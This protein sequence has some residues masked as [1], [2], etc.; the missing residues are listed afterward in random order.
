MDPTTNASGDPSFMPAAGPDSALDVLSLD[1]NTTP[2]LSS[3]RVTT[4]PY[5]PYVPDKMGDA[6]MLGSVHGS[7]DQFS[8]NS[9][10]S[11]R[12][13]AHL[14][15]TTVYNPYDTK[16]ALN[17][18]ER[19]GSDRSAPPRASSFAAA[20]SALSR[21]LTT[22][23]LASRS[24][25]TSFVPSI[26]APT[27][28][29]ANYAS[30]GINNADD[31]APSAQRPTNPM[32][33]ERMFR[34]LMDRRDFRSLPQ[35]ARQEMMNYGVD[36]KWMLIYQD[37]LS[38]RN[39][40]AK[41]A[42]A[43]PEL[44]TRKL[45]SKQITCEELE[46]LWVS[47]RT[48]PID[49]VREFIFDFQG[50]VALSLY[51]IKVHDQIGDLNIEHILDDIFTKELN[52]LKCL[53]CMMN[54][55]LG[56]ERAKADDALY[57]NAISGALL[58]PRL[59]TRRIATE[60]LTFLIV[61]Y[62]TSGSN[63]HKSKYH[64]VLKALDSLSTR[65]YYEFV[66]SAGAPTSMN[67][68]TLKR[69]F[70][71]SSLS[72]RFQLWLGIVAR[73]LG[74][75]GKYH[76]SLVGASEE[77]KYASSTNNASQV[78]N[79]LFEY[80]LSTMLLVNT[81]VEYGIDFRAR[82][83]LRSQLKGA[84]IELLMQNFE[85]MGF[86][87]LS[88]QC[89]KYADMA[90]ADEVELKA[91]ELIDA[92]IDFN[93][94]V[95][96]VNSLWSLVQNSEA[97]GVFISTIQ[98]LFL[99]QMDK[100][101]DPE[102]RMRSLR[103]LDGLVQNV[104]SAHTND[105]SAIGIAMNRLFQG[106]TTDD[107]Y[108]KALAEVKTQRK[109]A[110][111]ATAERDEMS[112]Q[113]SLGS[114]GLITSLTN[115]VREQ[116][117]VL[118]RTRKLNEEM[119]DELEEFKRKYLMEKQEQEMEMRELLIM[120]NSADIKSRRQDGKTTYSV[121]TSNTELVSK[122]QNQ[123]NRKKRE[124]RLDNKQLRSLIEP[125]SRLR[126]LREQMNDIENLARELEMTDF[127][128]YTQ[129]EATEIHVE[130][131]HNQI[132]DLAE[133][134]E[135]SEDELPP[136][137]A[138]P[139]P[140]PPV[141]MGPRR[142]MRN[143]DLEK[144]SKLRQQLSSLQ[145][146]SN[147]IMKF[148]NSKMFSKQK[149]LAMD[150][151][152]EL[153]NNFKDF[154]IDFD[155]SEQD[156][157][158]IAQ[159][160]DVN[161]KSRLQEEL[162]EIEKLKADLHSQLNALNKTNEPKTPKSKRAS[163]NPTTPNVDLFNKIESKY[164][165]GK[166][167]MESKPFSETKEVDFRNMKTV[168]GMDPKF[169]SE[170]T[171]K[172]KKTEAIDSTPE[173]DNE[174]ENLPIDD[175]PKTTPLVDKKEPVKA[176]PPPPPPPPL[177]P[178]LGG[179]E[180][181]PPPPPPPP[182]PPLLGGLGSA[183]PPPPLPPLL[184]GGGPPPP[185]PPP[186]M[187]GGLMP[188]PPPP[189][190][191]N[192]LGSVTPVHMPSPVPNLFD[193]YPRPKKKLKQLHWEKMDSMESN[194]MSFWKN[195]QPQTIVTQL[196]ERGV[197]DEI[198]VIFAAKEIRNLATKKKE[199]V[200]KI[201]FLPR[202][203]AQQFGINLHFFNLFSDKEVV[204]KILRCDKDVLENPTVL[205]FL[206]KDE[207]VE[208]PNSLALSLQPYST[209]YTSE[210]LAKPEKDPSE[211]Q[212]SDR[213]YLELI[214][215]LQHYWKSRIRALRTIANYE[216]DYDDL[217]FK[218]R[219]IDQSVLKIK[220]SENLRRVFEI[221]L[222]VGN[223]MN[224]SSKQAKGFKL[225]SLQR[226]GFVKDDKNSMSFLHYVEKVIR[227][228]YPEYLGF[229]EELASCVQAAKYSIEV[230]SNDCRDYA[231][232]IKNVQSLIDVGNLSDVSKFHPQ[233]RVLK[234]ISPTLPKAKKKA[235]LLSDQAKY[236]FKEL[237]KLMSFF[238]EDYN[239]IFIKNLFLSKF[240]NFAAEFKKAQR[241]NL[242]RE[243]ELKVYEQRKKL[244][245]NTSKTNTPKLDVSESET[246]NVMDSLLEKLK[247]AGLDRGEPTS[248][249]KRILMKKHLMQ[250]SRPAEE[251]PASAEEESPQIEKSD[252]ATNDD[253]GLRARSLLQELRKTNDEDRPRTA[254]EFRQER[255]RRGLKEEKKPDTEV[256]DT[257]KGPADGKIEPITEEDKTESLNGD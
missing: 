230:V 32:E 68:A 235:E 178:L 1:S 197:L 189:L 202:D 76:N 131:D 21:K 192:K 57:V 65:P 206:A 123:I 90:D 174:A 51:L 5:G 14:L 208:V 83:H 244:L 159:L 179:S 225:N 121:Q 53:R 24:T 252:T 37:Q 12:L 147:D 47:L 36:K 84:G 99:N 215:N 50:D 31:S 148:N 218:L 183:P 52:T 134:S 105:D 62:C 155:Y 191:G 42:H 199:D 114:E 98:H 214:Y 156:A 94:P 169:L 108:R 118:R 101:D 242:K 10:P 203:I 35:Q 66:S 136:E 45:I 124:A 26:T 255:R 55:K 111:E 250:N 227:L 40:L 205:E 137:E 109:I 126:A 209:D 81:I 149:F 219:E 162:G 17:G 116:E 46:N 9:S 164:S 28:F 64:R 15:Q 87:S 104:A 249:R 19:V 236:T 234:V 207:I 254:S 182:M 93:N 82:I 246:D 7:R 251:A 79:Q 58:S 171:S 75:R 211:L 112:R 125:S 122:L 217:V 139:S 170:L 233:D 176:G 140:P 146:E 138:S 77:L 150:R 16:T 27:S 129:P 144:L 248:A 29:T 157:A 228:N 143:D 241:E 172:V 78:E 238:G 74:G 185:P 39:K 119:Q 210:E 232:A 115:E 175:Q 216:K 92:N 166:V 22:I 239:D 96:L 85:E 61:Y 237:E 120:L 167:Q 158:L 245:E 91:D 181:P 223:Y 117:I 88:K 30:S 153:E 73:T 196:M 20:S 3:R 190:P 60:T 59:A 25:A 113:L 69:V 23:L 106:L 54:Q 165:Q 201:T 222:A 132:E 103:L 173:N 184:G 220:D 86:E 257:P 130:A 247:A 63:E 133:E 97:E 253:V 56:A 163:I 256:E 127:E 204:D 240:T 231:Q 41:K 70:P 200:D 33:V 43:S 151:L 13:S 180:A 141:V 95:E 100:K 145:S 44:Y 188:P 128:N 38:E 154:N 226:L 71:S 34:E 195:S 243:E 198:E 102:D 213:L 168:S 161:V 72:Q 8:V 160:V 152:K 11:R 187:F 18:D 135:E 2:S 80:C 48:E 107:M 110:A 229:L 177:P 67:Q 186:P 212:R 89:A 224:D 4:S 221:I 142:A 49:W 6:S 193:Q 194:A